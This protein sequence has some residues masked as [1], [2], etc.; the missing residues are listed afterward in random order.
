MIDVVF[1]YRAGHVN[2]G[3][4]IMRCDQLCAMA[5]ERLGGQYR[6]S[7]LALPRPGHVGRQRKLPE[8]LRGAVV[9][10]LKRADR[11]LDPEVLAELRQ[12]VRAMCLD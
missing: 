8:A 9:I 7:T 11:A 10:F 12:T 5:Q 6:F 1:L 3:A 2:S 4:K